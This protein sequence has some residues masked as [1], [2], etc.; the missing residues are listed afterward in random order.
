MKGEGNNNWRCGCA[1]GYMCTSGCDKL[2]V[3]HTCEECA[4]KHKPV[5]EKS[6]TFEEVMKNQN[7]HCKSLGTEFKAKCEQKLSD[8]VNLSYLAE[9]A[10]EKR[11]KVKQADEIVRT[12]KQEEETAKQHFTKLMSKYYSVD[13]KALLPATS[14]TDTL[15]QKS[16]RDQERSRMDRNQALINERATKSANTTAVSAYEQKVEE[17]TAE[18]ENKAPNL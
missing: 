7:K 3:G 1:K 13:G 9:N 17:M 2:Q 15:I 10:R 5:G 16:K 4:D 6:L 18:L 11:C 12:A 8:S 14:S